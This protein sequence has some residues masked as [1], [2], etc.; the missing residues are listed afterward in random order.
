VTGLDIEAIRR[1]LDW[2]RACEEQ[3]RI[4]PGQVSLHGYAAAAIECGRDVAVL[5]AELDRLRADCHNE[6]F[7]V[8]RLRGE[9]AAANLRIERY[10]ELP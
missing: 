3:C 4:S 5:V 7:E 10:E 9:L 8:V 1:R 6:A 2:F